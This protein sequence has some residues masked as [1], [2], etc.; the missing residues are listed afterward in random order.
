MLTGTGAVAKS[1]ASPFCAT[2]TDPRSELQPSACV[3][4][5]HDPPMQA[6]FMAQH[7]GACI[8]TPAC[9]R[10]AAMQPLANALPNRLAMNRN[11]TAVASLFIASTA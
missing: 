1:P 7:G 6:A 9:D 8:S 11:K 3:L 10:G 2:A 4:A 5:K